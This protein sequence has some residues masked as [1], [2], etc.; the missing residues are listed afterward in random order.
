L[1]KNFWL[2]TLGRL[3]SLIGSGIQQIALPLFILDLTG[4]GTIMGTFALV[5]MLPRIAFAPIAGVLGDR[6]NRK[7]IMVNLDFLRGGLIL[8]L[9]GGASLGFLKLWVLFVGQFLI[10]TMDIFF[11]PATQAMLP[12]LVNREEL[13]R[14]NAIING[15]NSLSYIVGPALGGILYGFFGI[16]AVFLANGISFVASAVSELFIEYTYKRK[17]SKLTVK[18]AVKEILEGVRF[19]R[20]IPGLLFILL[21]AMISN[22]LIAPIFSVVFP[23]FAR[24]VAGFSSQQYGFLQSAWVIGILLGNLLLGAFLYKK[25]MYSLFS[26]GLI[27]ETLF[28]AIFSTVAFETLITYFGKGTW[29]YFLVLAAIFTVLGLFNAMVNTPLMTLFQKKTPTEIRS[30]AFS[31]MSMLSQLVVPLGSVIFG[32][33][34]DSVHVQWIIFCAMIVNTVVTI[35]FLAGGMRKFFTTENEQVASD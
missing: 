15:V 18:T 3:V 2:F 7:R 8:I 12:D 19:F 6:F 34:L 25:D 27:V 14:A 17:A 28:F 24:Q 29:T 32:F 13:A 21:F 11:D 26:T 10:S 23:Y 20:E 33:A 16:T 9:A 1:K 22:F 30:R 31:V 4:S 5:S 35:L